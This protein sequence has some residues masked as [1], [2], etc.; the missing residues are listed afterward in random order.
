MGLSTRPIGGELQSQHISSALIPMPAAPQQ[1]TKI[2]CF[3][4][5]RYHF[6]PNGLGTASIGLRGD[7][8]RNHHRGC[9][10][11]AFLVTWRCL[12]SHCKKL[13]NCLANMQ[14]Q[15]VR[16]SKET[17]QK[18]GRETSRAKSSRPLGPAKRGKVR[19]P[20][21]VIAPAC[22]SELLFPIYH[23]QVRM[24]L[25]LKMHGEAYFP[26]LLRSRKTTDRCYF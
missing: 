12:F 26:T 5:F 8:T 7:E 25:F 20:K 22:G 16:M 1:K 19:C 23:D 13:T 4:P 17:G 10:A 2:C 21:R 11:E 14:L 18:R 3:C 9:S 15:H 6:Q 24:Q